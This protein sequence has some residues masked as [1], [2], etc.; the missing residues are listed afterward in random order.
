MS[1]VLVREYA[2]VPFLDSQHACFVRFPEENRSKCVQAPD[3]YV[4][5]CV[6]VKLFSSAKEKTTTARR[7]VL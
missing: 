3:S 1:I 7:I 4:A 2:S 6:A 5:I